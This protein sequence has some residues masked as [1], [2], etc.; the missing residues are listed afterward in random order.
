M[1]STV[2]ESPNAENL[3]LGA[4]MV[5][6]NPFDDSGVP[7]GLI[8]VGNVTA[9]ELTTDDDRIQKFESMTHA[10]SLYKEVLRRR[11][12]SVRLAMDEFSPDIV[13][14]ML[15]GEKVQSAAQ[16][17]TAVV[18]EQLTDDA[19]LGNFYMPS[20][21]GPYSAISVDGGVA[22]TTL[23]ALDDDYEVIDATGLRPLI[24]LLPGATTAADGDIITVSYT[25]TAYASGLTQIRGGTRSKVRGSLLFIGDPS[26]G[27]KLQLE[28]WKLAFRPDGAFGLI[29][30]DFAQIAMV[31][32]VESDAANHPTEPLYRVTYL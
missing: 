17:A 24:H 32:T 12:V 6:I 5:Y 2:Y 21:F 28:I 1:G 13:A 19:R 16:A 9:L 30:E 31:G 7:Q 3:L 8:A 4:G 14:L 26:D 18:D 25:P 22:G 10:R 11:N 20:K 29:S 23:L 27:P 15:Q